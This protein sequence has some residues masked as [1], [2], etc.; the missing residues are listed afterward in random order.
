MI[1]FGEQVEALQLAYESDEPLSF[2]E[3]DSGNR[4]SN[5]YVKSV[6]SESVEDDSIE[7]LAGVD[8]SQ[9]PIYFDI[10]YNH[11]KIEQIVV[12]RGRA[13]TPYGKLDDVVLG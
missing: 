11:G 3:T 1:D 8:G 2:V 6:E 10:E 7:R 5:V 12:R 9:V 13:K 4:L